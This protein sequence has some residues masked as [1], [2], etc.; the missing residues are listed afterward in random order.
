MKISVLIISLLTTGLS[1]SQDSTVTWIKNIDTLSFKML[2]GKKDIPK[3]FY[4]FVEIKS[5][6]EIANPTDEWTPSCIRTPHK[7]L[8]WIAKD[9]NNHWVLSVTTG[10]K[11]VFAGYYF[12]DK[13]KGKLNFNELNFRKRY[14]T[15]GQT[16]TCIKS[17]QFSFDEFDPDQ[18]K[19][20]EE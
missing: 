13:E 10:G 1:F 5:L 16:I 14:M 20:D 9:K 11:G 12:F 3:E 15:F 19:D 8:H 6:K 4:K 18:Y 7:K 2:T 17:G